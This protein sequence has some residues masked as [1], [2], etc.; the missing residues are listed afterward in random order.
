MYPVAHM[1][2]EQSMKRIRPPVR[3]D[4]RTLDD[5]ATASEVFRACHADLYGHEL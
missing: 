5:H 2:N 4:L 1:A 3:A